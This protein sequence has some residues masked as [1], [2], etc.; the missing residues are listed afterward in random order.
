MIAEGLLNSTLASEDGRDYYHSPPL[1]EAVI[2]RHKMLL[3]PSFPPGIIFGEASDSYF[4]LTAM[5]KDKYT[6]SNFNQREWTRN[7]CAISQKDS[8]IGP[9]RRR[10]E[11][12]IPACLLFHVLSC[13]MASLL[14][15]PVISPSAAYASLANSEPNPESRCHTI[16]AFSFRLKTRHIRQATSFYVAKGN[17]DVKHV[18]SHSGANIPD[19]PRPFDISPLHASPLS[20]ILSIIHFVCTQAS[21]SAIRGWKSDRLRSVTSAISRYGYLSLS[22][23]GVLHGDCHVSVFQNRRPLL[24]MRHRDRPRTEFRNLVFHH[25]L[26]PPDGNLCDSGFAPHYGTPAYF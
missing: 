24:P 1:T 19:S 8:S 23:R 12:I 10:M 15:V 3:A 21:T 2:G 22:A 11:R 16:C 20:S 13:H 26:T 9:T 7:E 18:P 4:I 17:S 14:P 6:S 5:H 25:L